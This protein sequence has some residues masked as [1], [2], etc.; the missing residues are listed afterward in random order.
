MCRHMC[1]CVCDAKIY[2]LYKHIHT[3]RN[4]FPRICVSEFV[5]TR[6]LHKDRMIDQ[7][8]DNDISINV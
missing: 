2:I 1:V 5:F 6:S 7:Y 3:Y 8:I 4:T